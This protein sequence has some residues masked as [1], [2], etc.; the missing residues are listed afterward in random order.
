MGITAQIE[1]CSRSHGRYRY[2][3]KIELMLKH[4][5]QKQRRCLVS[6]NHWWCPAVL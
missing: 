4:T 2:P 6:Q 1:A 3:P 5:K